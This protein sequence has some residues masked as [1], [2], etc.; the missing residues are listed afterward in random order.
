[1][2]K[3]NKCG[4]CCRV[5]KGQS[6][7][8][9]ILLPEDIDTISAAFGLN[10]KSFIDKYCHHKTIFFDKLYDLYFIKAINEK[11]IFLNES[12][13]SIHHCKP[14]QCKLAPSMLFTTSTLW[15]YM[16]CTE[17]KQKN[18]IVTENDI[19]F[20]KSIISGYNI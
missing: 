13:C 19:E 6:Y 12:L 14:R 3:C 15:D 2:N 4:T 20:V 17:K 9:V 11:C 8:N 5:P 18:F 1:M 10:K 16:P 7:I